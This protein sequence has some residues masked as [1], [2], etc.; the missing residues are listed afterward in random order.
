MSP[1][2]SAQQKIREA[3]HNG[4]GVSLDPSETRALHLW[5]REVAGT[6]PEEEAKFRLL[7]EKVEAD[8]EILR[9]ENDTLREAIAGTDAPV[10]MAVF[11]N[12]LAR[13][14]KCFW[15]EADRSTRIELELAE[16]RALLEQARA[17]LHGA[18]YRPPSPAQK[19]DE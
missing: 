15:T 13:S 8:N 19:G 17:Q 11:R 12:A 10:P 9:G 18:D 6:A 1:I 14:E 4:K 5:I 3:W 7:F 2:A 16:T